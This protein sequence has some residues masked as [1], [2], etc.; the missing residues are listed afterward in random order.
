MDTRPPQPD[1]RQPPLFQAAGP[2]PTASFEELLGELDRLVGQLESGQLS[3]ED[4]L[5]A[6][7]RGMAVSK[8][9]AAILDSAELRIEQLTS[10]SEGPVTRP[11]DDASL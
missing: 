8:R 2:D 7:E 6:F 4:S 3:L 5:S 11:M 10:T 9:A 1:N